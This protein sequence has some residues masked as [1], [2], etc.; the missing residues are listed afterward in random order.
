MKN[1]IILLIGLVAL[2]AMFPSCY[3]LD[4]FPQDKLSSGTFWR[5]DDHA[6]QAVMACYQ[7]MKWAEVYNQFFAM[8]CLTDIG[9][10][11]DSQGYWDISRGVWTASHRY[12]QNRWQQTYEGV[13]R[14]NMAIFNISRSE[15]ISDDIKAVTIAEAK[16]MRALYYFFLMNHFGD[17]PIYDET[18]D[19]NANYMDMINP[20]DPIEKV[21][22]F[23]LRDLETAINDLPVSWPQTDYGRA[24]KGAAYAL[25]GK[26][27]LYDQQYD[28]AQKD[29]EEIVLDPNKKGY[30]YELYPDYAGLFLPGGD[31]SKEMIFAIQNMSGAGT[32]NMGMPFAHYMGS[33]AS[34]GVSWNNAMPSVELVDSYELKDG[35]SFNWDDFIPGFND[36]REVREKTFMAVLSE[37][38]KTV[39]KYPEYYKELLDMY[40]QRDPRMKQTIIL[41]Y[42]HYTGW[43]GNK[44]KDCEY[45]VATGVTTTNG[46]IVVNRGYRTYL[47]RKFVPEGNMD[48]LVTSRSHIPINFPII[49]YAD[50]L[51][52]LAEC[53]NELNQIDKA[54]A[55]IN[56][57]R[58]RPSTNLPAL[59]SGPMWLEA[60][61]KED[62]FKRIMQERAVEF[63]AEGHRYYDI[64][65]WKLGIKMLNGDEVDFLGNTIYVNKFE[66]KNYLWPIP[67]AERDRNSN[68]TQNPGW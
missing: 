30:G 57:V 11:Y 14:T 40:E 39:V 28:L 12:A 56:Q 59:N 47:Y 13:S 54:I 17:V 5:T 49:R 31:E 4:R 68:L 52:M 42:T 53:Y 29:F 34:I 35:R 27:Y 1:R 66:E 21:R 6:K 33:N 48:G 2:S 51:L 19:Y 36:S 20:R 67:T 7:S 65:R 26:V 45:V 61:T 22:E 46:F 50:V 58:Q 25:R 44:N 32:F 62:V 55:C 24:T 60:R 43:V 63:P 23:I 41:P 38:K 8:D 10:G 18:W 15:T 3:D 37:D 16:F 9:T 64:K